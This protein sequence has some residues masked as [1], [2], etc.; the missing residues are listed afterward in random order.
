MIDDITISTAIITI[1]RFKLILIP[2]LNQLVSIRRR[3]GYLI[4]NPNS[5]A[6]GAAFPRPS[7]NPERLCYKKPVPVS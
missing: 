4:C 6:V 7:N 5:Q 3:I 1:P 2:T